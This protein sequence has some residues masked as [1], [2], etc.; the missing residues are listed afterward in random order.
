M[1]PGG[2]TPHSQGLSNNPSPEP[3]QPKLP[4][5]TPIYLRCILIL[6]SDLR[7][8]LPKPIF[9]VDLPVKILKAIPP[10]SILAT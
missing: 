8:R 5:M 6:S 1:K 10:S 7:L 9:P 4:E 3:N 2:S